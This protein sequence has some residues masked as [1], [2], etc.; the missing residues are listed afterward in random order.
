MFQIDTAR[1]RL[2]KRLTYAGTIPLLLCTFATLL[3]VSSIE[4]VRSAICYGAIIVSF[5]C[6]IHWALFLLLGDRCRRNLLLYSNGIAL[7][8][9][10]S[11][12]IAPVSISLCIL[13]LCFM[14]LLKLDT[15]LAMADIYPAWYAR[16]RTNAT[17]IVMLNLF[18]LIGY[19][20][21]S[22]IHG[23]DASPR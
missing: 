8:A 16:L 20:T 9:W 22:S 18:V 4:A 2:V 7:A 14:A 17:T 1:E 11:L 23:I 15:E 21:I 10:S 5:L 13:A 19:V 3:L 12:L 6:G